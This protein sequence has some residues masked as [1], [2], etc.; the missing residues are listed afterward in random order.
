M[1]IS[2]P[3]IAK[4]V[5][6]EGKE[7]EYSSGPGAF[8]TPALDLDALVWPRTRPGPLF[9][10]PCADIIDALVETGEALRRDRDGVLHEAMLSLV[11]AGPLQRRIAENSYAQ[12]HRQ[13]ARGRTRGSRATHEAQRTA[14]PR[15]PAFAAQRCRAGTRHR[16]PC[17][18][19]RPARVTVPAHAEVRLHP[20]V[21][22]HARHGLPGQQHV[23]G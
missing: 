4:G 22:A 16:L 23:T 2:V 21:D 9:D 18:R 17:A 1:T 8:V 12:L 11:D 13:F 19:G 7:R 15:Q 10:V 6:V 20:A 3:H 14:G 5:L